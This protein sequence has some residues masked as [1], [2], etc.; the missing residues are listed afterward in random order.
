VNLARVMINSLIMN[1]RDSKIV[2]W[3]LEIIRRRS[4]A[5]VILQATERNRE[6]FRALHFHDTMGGCRKTHRL[7][8]FCLPLS[9]TCIGACLVF[10]A[11][12]TDA[13]CS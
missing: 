12:G 7:A 6:V 2:S 11:I 3:Y 5:T 8:S 13:F 4:G 1:P 10:S 9:P